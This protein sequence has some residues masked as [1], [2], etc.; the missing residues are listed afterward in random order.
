MKKKK[1]KSYLFVL[2]FLIV[3]GLLIDILWFS[4][5]EVTELK[6]H[7]SRPPT[8]RVSF[9]NFSIQPTYYHVLWGLKNDQGVQP[10]CSDSIYNKAPGGIG[11]TITLNI[12]VHGGQVTILTPCGPAI[13]QF[14]RVKNYLCQVIATWSGHYSDWADVDMT[15]RF[16]F[17]S[18][19]NIGITINNYTPS[20]LM[21]G[22]KPCTW[23]DFRCA[24]Q[25]DKL[26]RKSGPINAIYSN[27][28]HLGGII[29]HP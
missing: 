23:R 11:G 26:I 3:I 2:L 5:Y 14:G 28:S 4:N 16:Q 27:H 9:Q 15:F 22:T 20:P 7:T 8:P 17:G 12:S 10:I 13:T 21:M 18:V 19:N 6:I 24:P 1:Y 25:S 29:R